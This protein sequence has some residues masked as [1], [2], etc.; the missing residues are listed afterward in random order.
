[1]R[2]LIE[3]LTLAIICE[4]GA[5]AGPDM[6]LTSK[7]CSSSKEEGQMISSSYKI[8][9]RQSAG[10]IGLE[11][12]CHAKEWARLDQELNAAYK[13][14]STRLEPRR[15]AALKESQRAWLAMKGPH[16]II[17]AEESGGTQDKSDELSC[18]IRVLAY[19]V[20]YL[21]QLQ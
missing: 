7:S 3:L 17:E 2:H 13:A 21:R 4:V 11:A 16:C 15:A 20:C 9:M 14:A 10:N 1:M 19:R 12:D 5:A 6:S 18:S 8:C